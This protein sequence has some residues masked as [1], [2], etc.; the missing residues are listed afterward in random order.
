MMPDVNILPKWAQELIAQ[1]KNRAAHARHAL[2]KFQDEQTPSPIFI[3][4]YVCTDE[5]KGPTL[6][7]KYLQSHKIQIKYEGVWLEI[8]LRDGYIDVHWGDP[9]GLPNDVAMIPYSYQ[10]IKLV[11]RDNMRSK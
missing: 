10:Q 8:I 2:N 3:E 5:K 11:S 6:K 4:D 1:L 9:D 7:R